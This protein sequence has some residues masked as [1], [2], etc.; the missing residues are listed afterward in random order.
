[1]TA[2]AIHF[3]AAESR[4][5]LAQVYGSNGCWNGNRTFTSSE[6]LTCWC[7]Q[8]RLR[9]QYYCQQLTA[10]LSFNFKENV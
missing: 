1:M 2:C 8:M 5:T 3:L 9:V 6:C 7:L 4:Y 10:R